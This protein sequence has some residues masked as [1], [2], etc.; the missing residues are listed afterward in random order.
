MNK[1][2][3]PHAGLRLW[4]EHHLYSLTS[5]IGRSLKKPGASFLTVAVMALALTLP[6]TLWLALGNLQRF[7][8]NV[9]DSREISVFLQPEVDAGHAQSLL[10]ELRGDAGIAEVRWHTP[11]QGLATLGENPVLADAIGQLEENP[12]P[13]V[14]VLTPR[15]EAD[16]D[17]LVQRLEQLPETELVQH[18]ALWRQRLDRWLDFGARLALVLAILLG[19]G[20]LL[21]VGNTVRL[22]I[23]SRREELAILQLLGATDGFIRRPFL[24]LGA[25]YGL[26]AG[27]L[28]LALLALV[29]HYLGA[30]LAQLAESY[31]SHF[32]LQG[33]GVGRN[34]A[35]VL[36]AAVLGWLGAALV[37]SHYLRKT[38][39]DSRP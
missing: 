18:D 27:A 23:Q 28:A 34:L 3:A 30:P 39:P 17:A 38:R 6:L 21:V 15:R 31:A 25:W 7:A 16:E 33:F 32:A 26:L 22:D 24:Y 19:G 1:P 11:E 13:H 37:S 29:R 10:Q 5:G 20:A 8:G 2:S 14:F 36:A 35:I 9:Q 4:W 12:L